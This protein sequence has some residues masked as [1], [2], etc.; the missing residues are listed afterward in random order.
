LEPVERIGEFRM[1]LE[2]GFERFGSTREVF[3]VEPGPPALVMPF[4]AL[5]IGRH[6][7]PRRW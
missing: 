5:Q 2:R 7:R 4:R 3:R 6:G 1:D